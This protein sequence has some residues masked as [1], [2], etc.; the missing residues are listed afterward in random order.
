MPVLQWVCCVYLKRNLYGNMI[1]IW[2]YLGTFGRI[3]MSF[4]TSLCIFWSSWSTVFCL[5][6]NFLVCGILSKMSS[7]LT[8][9]RTTLKCPKI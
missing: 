3:F 5:S 6:P 8:S 4:F 7:G 9:V 1:V 2:P